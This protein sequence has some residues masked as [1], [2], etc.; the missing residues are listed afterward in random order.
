[1]TELKEHARE[2]AND[3]ELPTEARVALLALCGVVDHYE[4]QILDLE[5]KRRKAEYN[6]A[7]TKLEQASAKLKEHKK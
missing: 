4:W 2:I 7:S 1:M 6:Y 5:V 3:P